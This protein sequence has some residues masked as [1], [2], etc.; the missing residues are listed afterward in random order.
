MATFEGSKKTYS[1]L[2]DEE[3]TDK[4]NIIYEE[5][6]K[7]GKELFLKEH[8]EYVIPEKTKDEKRESKQESRANR[9]FRKAVQ[10]R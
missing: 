10:K 7:Q 3:K 8:P 2:S 9:R 5:G 6:Y 1:Q 4:L